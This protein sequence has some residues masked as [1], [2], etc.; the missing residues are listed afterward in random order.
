MNPITPGN[1][2][3]SRT[4]GANHLD[5]NVKTESTTKSFSGLGGLDIFSKC[6]HKFNLGAQLGEFLPNCKRAL[7]KFEDLALGFAGGAE[8]LADMAVLAKDEGFLAICDEKVYTPKSYGDFL[9]E[10]DRL[11]IDQGN[12]RLAKAAFVQ[13]AALVPDQKS[14]VLDFDSTTNQQFAEKMEG[15]CF[16]GEKNVECL[17]TM[18]VFDELGNQYFSDVRPGNTRT[19]NSI[20]KII[21]LI[22][23]EMPK[24]GTYASEDIFLPWKTSPYKKKFRTYARADCGYSNNEFI[25]ACIGKDIGFVLRLHPNMLKPKIKNIT[26]WKD[27]KKRRKKVKRRG[28]REEYVDKTMRFYDGRDTE[29]GTTLYYNNEINGSCRI[30]CLRAKKPDMLGLDEED[31]DYFAW[32]TNIG[33][34]EMGNEKVIPFYRKRGHAE[35]YIRELKNGFDMHHYP[36]LKLD[37]NRAYALIAAFSHN[38]LRFISHRTAKSKA[39]FAKAIRN[40]LIYLPCQVVR[41]GRQVF[42]RYMEHQA[43]EVRKF[44]KQLKNLQYGFT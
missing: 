6:W 37:A 27:T 21:H 19:S 16:S 9:R 36:C 3:D 4:L 1:S 28:G 43:K 31:Y 24:E 8:C 29:I 40:H 10:F 26:N 44:L 11:S 25:N 35:N 7:K 39:Q 30:V 38:I 33:E 5:K 18:Y 41:Q 22:M 20:S 14:M 2:I 42:F 17:T 12:R 13:R 23:S 32:L 15:V 34:H